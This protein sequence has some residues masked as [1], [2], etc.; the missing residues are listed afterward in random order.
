MTL[1]RLMLLTDRT[2]MQPSFEVALIA[3]MRGGAR[4]VQ[5]REKDLSP[6]EVLALALKAQRVCETFGAQVVVNSRA[7]IARAAHV[8]GVHLPEKDLSPRDARATLGH[9]SLCGVSVHNVDSATCAAQ[10]GADYLVFG[11]VFP[12]SSHPNG[13]IAGLQ[14]LQEVC[15]A[16][17][18]P[19]FAIGGITAQNAPDCL[20]AGA[21]GVAVI[22]A[23]WQSDNVCE[24]VQALVK[25]LS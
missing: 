16:T 6:R 11:S 21:Y 19:V 2:R 20:S 13:N 15:V 14:K 18:L 23:V 8:A 7:D 17:R 10:E 9:H 24:A 1:P 12:T 5:V 4:L 25:V 22:S 3:A